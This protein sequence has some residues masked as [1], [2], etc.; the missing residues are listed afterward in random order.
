[1]A[2]S[3]YE[4]ARALLGAPEHSVVDSEF[5]SEQTY[6]IGDY[7]WDTDPGGLDIT[8]QWHDEAKK[9]QVLSRSFDS[10]P[11]LFEALR[12]AEEESIAKNIPDATVDVAK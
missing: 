12:A 2:M 7:T 4:A 1:M 8:A 5:R 3:F 9:R 11:A 6:Q 10:L